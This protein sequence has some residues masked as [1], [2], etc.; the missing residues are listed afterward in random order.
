MNSK[1]GTTSLVCAHSAGSRC[2]EIHGLSYRNGYE[3]AWD[4]ASN[5][6]LV[7]ELVHEARAAEMEYLEKM[8]A[9]ARC[10]RSHR[11][12]T[13]EHYLSALH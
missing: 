11:L 10:L 13:G 1:E 8:G 3:M 4:D 2:S 5:D 6:K 7:F 9:Y 12:A